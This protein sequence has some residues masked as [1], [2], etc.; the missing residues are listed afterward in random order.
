[1]L[2]FAPSALADRCDDYGCVVAPAWQ[3]AQIDL[4]AADIAMVDS[5]SAQADAGVHTLQSAVDLRDK[6]SL[7]G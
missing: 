4:E 2:I 3:E 7:M 1:M 6:V 5:P